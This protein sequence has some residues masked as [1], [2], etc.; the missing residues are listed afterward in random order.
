LG[1]DTITI[2]REALALGGANLQKIVLSQLWLEF[3]QIAAFAKTFL[4]RNALL[5]IE[6]FLKLDDKTVI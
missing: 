3:W 6:T 1:V 5:K 2:A 4:M